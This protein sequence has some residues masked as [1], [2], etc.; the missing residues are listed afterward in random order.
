MRRRTGLRKPLLSAVLLLAWVPCLARAQA[1][2]DADATS[3]AIA[4]NPGA[5]NIAPGTGKLG[6]LLG[7]D[8]ENGL[9]LGGVL[10]SNGNYLISGGKAPAT[11]SFNNLL[12]TD[13]QS[14]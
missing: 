5:V 11:T 13:F 8:P 12:L 7:F 4:G 2:S 10:V 1:S 6:R 3:S 9:R 14:D